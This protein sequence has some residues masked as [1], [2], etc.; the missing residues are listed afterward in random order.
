MVSLPLD[1]D[2]E[3]EDPE[4]FYNEHLGSDERVKKA[5]RKDDH[6]EEAFM[7]APKMKY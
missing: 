3:D 6:P 7:M 2:D 4:D 5:P 1:D